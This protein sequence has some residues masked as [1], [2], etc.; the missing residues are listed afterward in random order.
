MLNMR[1]VAFAC[2]DTSVDS[3]EVKTRYRC[4][5]AFSEEGVYDITLDQDLDEDYMD[6]SSAVRGGT[7][8]GA[9]TVRSL[10]VVSTSNTVKRL[11]V[12]D[13]T[14]AFA[15]PATINITFRRMPSVV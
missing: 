6:V 4:S 3:I 15:T 13:D 10:T 9:G 5:V 12:R 1:P 2:F 8:E 14:G 7:T 11:L